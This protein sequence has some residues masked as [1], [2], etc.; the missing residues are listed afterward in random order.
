MP[1]RL[2]LPRVPVPRPG[3]RSATRLRNSALTTTR[4][5]TSPSSVSTVTA[6]VAAP[7]SVPAKTTERKATQNAAFAEIPT[8]TAMVIWSRPGLP[9][10]QDSISWLG[11]Q[12]D[13]TGEHHPGPVGGEQELRD[14]EVRELHDGPRGACVDG[15]NLG[16][17]PFKNLYDKIVGCVTHRE[18]SL[19]A[20]RMAVGSTVRTYSCLTGAA[21]RLRLLESDGAAPAPLSPQEDFV[22]ELSSVPTKCSRVPLAPGRSAQLGLREGENRQEFRPS[23]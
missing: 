19:R 5:M 23:V 12:Q 8:F 18:P 22:T 14:H 4:S 1:P 11:D 7:R 20:A 15:E 17:T 9:W 2:C 16:N 13:R 3:E 6:V 21:N 10:F